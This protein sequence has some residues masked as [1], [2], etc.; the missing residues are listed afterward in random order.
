MR[1]KKSNVG[2]KGKGIW[3]RKVMEI[4]RSSWIHVQHRGYVRA[5]AV[6]VLHN[7]GRVCAHHSG[8]GSRELCCAEHLHRPAQKLMM[9]LW[10]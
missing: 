1:K 7:R 3:G 4:E 2:R 6:P 8:E 10:G 5:E 9:L